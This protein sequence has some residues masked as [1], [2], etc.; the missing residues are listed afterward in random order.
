[1]QHG[2]GLPAII[3]C[4]ARPMRLR[5]APYL[6]KFP[7][8]R[9]IKHEGVPH[10]VRHGRA[11]SLR[12]QGCIGAVS[13]SAQDFTL[14]ALPGDHY[15]KLTMCRQ[16][17]NE[18]HHQSLCRLCIEDAFL[19]GRIWEDCDQYVRLG[20]ASQQ[21]VPSRLQ[22]RCH[23]LAAITLVSPVRGMSCR[24]AYPAV[25]PSRD[26][27]SGQAR[28]KRCEPATATTPIS[29]FGS[30]AEEKMGPGDHALP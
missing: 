11:G 15:G 29:E 21:V 14:S 24:C 30:F 7:F 23:Q 8:C 16:I 17:S 20:K 5:R 18:P 22:H 6:E 4:R 2:L 13:E 9:A 12:N 28:R 1:M 25:N 3:R 19:F 27:R 10:T 26:W